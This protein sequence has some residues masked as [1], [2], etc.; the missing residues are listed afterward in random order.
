MDEKNKN[1]KPILYV[2]IGALGMMVI[3]LAGGRLQEINIFGV[4]KF[5]FPAKAPLPISTTIATPFAQPTNL[6][7]SPNTN[8]QPVVSSAQLTENAIDAVIGKGHWRCIDGSPKS[9]SIDQVPYNYV[10][11][12]PFTRID[13][14]GNFYEVNERVSG[15]GLGTGW[16]VSDLPNF[17]CSYTKP[18]VNFEIINR[19]LESGKWK[20]AGESQPSGVDLFVVP[21][22]FTVQ[23][24]MI[25]VDSESKRYYQGDEVPAGK[26]AR[27]WF[28]NDIPQNECP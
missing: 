27:V 9:I 26:F 1:T 5:E 28:G 4:A 19:L 2:V 8:S 11:S 7:I 6:V 12:F 14:D 25:F 3:F 10:V 21:S 20:C 13:T 18:Q 16:L 15:G 24:P 23:S 22:N 17:S